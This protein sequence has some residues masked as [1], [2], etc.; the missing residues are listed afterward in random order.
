M[1]PRLFSA[2]IAALFV[3]TVHSTL[4]GSA[5]WNF[6]PV[7]NDWNDPLNWTP[8]TVPNRATDV[9]TFATSNI[10]D[11]AV[12]ADTTVGS[13]VYNAGA[14][15]FI[16]TANPSVDLTFARTGIIN[17][18]GTLQNFVVEGPFGIIDFTGSATAADATITA[19]GGTVEGFYG[20]NV[21][22]HDNSTAG[23]ATIILN[24]GVKTGE[25]TTVGGLGAFYD[26]AIGGTARFICNGGL[27]ITNGQQVTIGS[28]EGRGGVL[29]GGKIGD[30]FGSVLAVGSNNLSTH[31]A[32]GITFFGPFIK[33]GTGTLTLTGAGPG[34]GGIHVN[35]GILIVNTAGESGLGHGKVTVEGG[36]LAGSGIIAGLVTVGSGSGAGGFL[37]PAAGTP[38]KA[39]LTLQSKLTFKN[40]GTYTYT[41]EGNGGDVESDE[42][43]AN[44]VTIKNA[45]VNLVGT[46]PAALETGTVLTVISNTS[47][48]P[49][50]GTFSNLADGAIVTINGNKLQASYTGGDG[51]DLTLT[52]VP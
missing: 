33:T 42:V 9:A 13:I 25:G 1:K 38:R 45:T 44:G 10:T 3:F 49:I 12:T 16:I 37:A 21:G 36:T 14:S 17:N 29:I 2:A 35:E 8:N 41:F 24:Q 47:A 50:S 23:N 7:S 31:Y 18:S 51:N 15:A 32:G 48:N 39:T 19:K 26:S 4:A 5:T 30:G 22:F 11:I 28:L 34:H 40:D 6:N 20:G 46:T 43:I 27:S 52:V